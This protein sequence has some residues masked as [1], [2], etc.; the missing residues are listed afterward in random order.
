[1]IHISDGQE[2]TE[3]VV[4]V[5][6]GFDNTGGETFAVANFATVRADVVL[7]EELALG[8]P[9]R[10]LLVNDKPLLCVARVSEYLVV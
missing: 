3:T 7:T 2:C 9:K 1:M 10:A 4:I 6:G 8:I 5:L